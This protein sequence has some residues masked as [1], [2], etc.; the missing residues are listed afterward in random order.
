AAPGG[1]G[2]GADWLSDASQGLSQ[3]SERI[4]SGLTDMS[5]QLSEQLSAAGLGSWFE[6]SGRPAA[7]AA[8]AQPA[9]PPGDL[10]HR[11]LVVGRAGALVR[12]RVELSSGEVY[13][14]PEG[15]GTTFIALESTR[16]AEG[17][18]RLRIE[19]P[20]RGWL[21]FKTDIVKRITSS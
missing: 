9:P 18:W 19:D 3:T 8:P 12:E 20:V 6:P 2:G 10:P 14:I 1:G 7:G 4:Q 11:F 5:R 13:K 17:T 15:G 16:T 21:S